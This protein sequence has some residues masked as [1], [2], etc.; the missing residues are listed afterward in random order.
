MFGSANGIQRFVHGKTE[1]YPVGMLARQ[2]GVDSFLWDRDG[3]LWVGT[4]SGLVHIHR[5]RAELFRQVDGLSANIVHCVFEDREGNIWVATEGGL[6]RFR[7]FAVP[8][9]S[10]KEGFPDGF[11]GAILA[12]RDGSL[13]FSTSDRLTKWKNSEVTVDDRHGPANH[14]GVATAVREIHDSGLRAQVRGLFQ[15]SRGRLWVTTLGGFGYMNND[16]FVLV[17]SV[18]GDDQ[19]LDRRGRRRGSVVFLR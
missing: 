3:N 7:D 5:G 4:F 12:T 15:D 16:S 17:K 11:Y 2:F 13:W 8:T 10:A 1:V 9:F 19:G 14:V 18:P 6:D